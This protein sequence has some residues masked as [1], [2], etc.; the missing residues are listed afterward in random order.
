VRYGGTTRQW[1]MR[2]RTAKS[3]KLIRRNK[4]GTF[5]LAQ[6]GGKSRTTRRRWHVVCWRR[7]PPSW[8]SG[9]SCLLPG[10]LLCAACSENSSR[11]PVAS[12]FPPQVCQRAAHTA[13]ADEMMYYIVLVLWFSDFSSPLKFIHGA[14]IV[15]IEFM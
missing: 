1:R 7:R 2:Q 3:K 12:S 15:A 11:S 8:C 4:R 10:S 6:V 9:L 5:L 13:D 14:F